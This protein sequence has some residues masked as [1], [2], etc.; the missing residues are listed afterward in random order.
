[1][2][3]AGTLPES[4][5][6]LVDSGIF[7]DSREFLAYAMTDPAFQKFLMETEGQIKQS[8]FTQ[9]VNNVRQF[10]NMGPIHTSALSDVI[11]ITDKMLSARMTP[12]MRA[13][14]TAEQE[15]AKQ[16][17]VSS[18]LKEKKV[19]TNKI[20]Q[21]M[22]KSSFADVVRDLPLLVNLR[23][24]QDFTDALSSMY[25]GFD[26]FKLRQILPAL[27]TDAVVQWADRLGIKGVKE[28]YQYLNDMAAMR[29]K[30]TLDMVPVSEALAKLAR[31]SPE[32]MQRLANTM[33]YSTLLYRDPTVAGNLTKD[34]DLKK[35]WDG[36]TD[37]NKKLYEQVRD[38]YKDNHEQY[39]VLL[40]EQIANS[41]LAGAAG[42]GKSPKGKLIAQIKQ[43]SSLSFSASMLVIAETVLPKS[44][45]ISLP[46]FT[47]LSIELKIS[48][49]I[50]LAS[51]SRLRASDK[52]LPMS[53]ALDSIISLTDSVE[54]ASCI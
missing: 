45:T 51:K 29:N 46:A 36:L 33:H 44:S 40:E 18:Q 13:E 28:S 9:F 42:D 21:R 19:K 24:M 23:S 50:P 16:A 32:Q 14:V 12:L 5:Y 11:N 4:M 10:F 48:F 52:S 43:I 15:S 26:N 25:A 54:P 6:E 31:N 38:F 27:Q 2:Q 1:M 37:A 39:H 8:L 41:K 20:L 53:M 47:P 30:R 17:E 7:D 49:N 3:E 35:L 22:E 34:A